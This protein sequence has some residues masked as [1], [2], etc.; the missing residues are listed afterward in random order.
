M[1]T[2]A[3]VWVE[4][5]VLGPSSGELSVPFTSMPFDSS[6]ICSTSS[7]R[8]SGTTAEIPQDFSGAQPSSYPGLSVTLSFWDA[9]NSRAYICILDT[10]SL[11]V[12]CLCVRQTTFHYLKTPAT[13]APSSR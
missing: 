11:M 3:S 4:P 7:Y 6:R 10:C 1:V 12:A 5:I 13:E 2:I 9:G 8:L